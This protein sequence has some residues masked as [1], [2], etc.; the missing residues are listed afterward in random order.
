MRKEDSKGELHF[1]WWCQELL[2]AGYIRSF[3]DHDYIFRLTPQFT[4]T[5]KKE[6]ITKTN[7]IQRTLLQPGT[8]TPDFTIEWDTTALGVITQEL[9]NIVLPMPIFSFQ[10]YEGKM[11][12]HIDV[13][14]S[15]NKRASDKEVFTWK[16]KITYM[17]YRIYVQPV[18]SATLFKKTFTPERY[19]FTDVLTEKH[20]I[21][22]K[23]KWEFRSL[24]QFIKD[25]DRKD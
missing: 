2:E 20:R 19:K 18:V 12:S 6:L 4:I 13:K 22:R 23:R 5:V 25:C 17:E 16:Q 8:Y 1:E 7:V 24:K 9:F 10:W 3:A 14:P 11:V 21:P 15:Y